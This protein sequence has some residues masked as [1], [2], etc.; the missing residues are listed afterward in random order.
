V[1][2]RLG[3]VETEMREGF[4]RVDA[5]AR[6]NYSMLAQGRQRITDLLTRNLDEPDDQP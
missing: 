1:E 5:E 3:N 4:E 6:K 2:S